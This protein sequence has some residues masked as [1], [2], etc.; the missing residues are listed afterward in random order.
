MKF[1]KKVN[2]FMGCMPDSKRPISKEFVYV[3]SEFIHNISLIL[4]EASAQRQALPAGGGIGGK[5]Q[6]IE[7]R[8]W[9]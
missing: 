7:S 5:M 2:R 4:L 9:G 8:F 3:C 6:K 1:C